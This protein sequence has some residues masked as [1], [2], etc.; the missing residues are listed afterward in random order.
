MRD[1]F[2]YDSSRS[3]TAEMRSKG[4]LVAEVFAILLRCPPCHN[5]MNADR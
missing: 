1:A 2:S 5:V 3:P 4:E